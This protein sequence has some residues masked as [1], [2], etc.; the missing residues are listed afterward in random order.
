MSWDISAQLRLRKKQKCFRK[1]PLASKNCRSCDFLLEGT[2]TVETF[3]PL[4][5]GDSTF[6]LWEVPLSC[7]PPH[8][9]EDITFVLRNRTIESALI[10][11]AKLGWQRRWYGWVF[12]DSF[13][14]IAVPCGLPHSFFFAHMRQQNMRALLP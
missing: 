10:S 7:G 12:S 6:L 11:A 2:F 8:S 13:Q 14:K 1:N 5:T 3:G 4:R 9:C